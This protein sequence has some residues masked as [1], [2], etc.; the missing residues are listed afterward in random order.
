MSS[1]SSLL[2]TLTTTEAEAPLHEGQVIACV[3][4]CSIAQIGLL[5]IWLTFF[6]RLRSVNHASNEARRSRY[7]AP[8]VNSP[9]TSA[10]D[11]RIFYYRDP[12]T[13]NLIVRLD[14]LV[15]LA[16]LLKVLEEPLV[17]DKQ[18]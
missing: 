2:P 5:I 14:F 1:S 15:N 8:P 7:N 18:H 9:S 3:A 11:D 10:G 13:G 17:D 12:T 16:H 6:F 4:V